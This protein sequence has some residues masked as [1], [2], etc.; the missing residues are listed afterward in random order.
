MDT[1]ELVSR[2]RSSV[3]MKTDEQLEAVELVGKTM[4]VG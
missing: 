2:K 3:R 1:M 4:Q